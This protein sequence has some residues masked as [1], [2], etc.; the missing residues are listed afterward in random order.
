MKKK[1]AKK[2][3]SEPKKVEKEAKS[4]LKRKTGL[5]KAQPDSE[6]NNKKQRKK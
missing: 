4:T 3:V 2:S 1:L 6:P 5:R